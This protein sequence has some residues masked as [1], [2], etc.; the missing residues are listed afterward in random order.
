MVLFTHI[1]EL[2][3]RF[4]FIGFSFVLLFGS[5]FSFREE[6]FILFSRS[7]EVL[8]SPDQLMFTGFGEVLRI[9]LLI[10]LF[11]CF[12][13]SLCLLLINLYLFLIPGLYKSEM[14]VLLK[15][16]LLFCMFWVSIF[17]II[18][19][20]C[21]YLICEYLV[22]YGAGSSVSI[23]FEPRFGEF[24]LFILKLD[25]IFII[26]ITLLV[27]YLYYIWRS[28]VVLS[29]LVRNRKWVYLSLMV[30]VILFVPADIVLHGMVFSILVFIY[31]LLLFVVCIGSVYKLAWLRNKN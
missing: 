27:G 12:L 18:H 17:Y 13:V 20:Y 10:S 2:V 22:G 11:M 23:R 26:I 5:F 14:L 31:E 29:R 16:L 4:G 1:K 19:Y 30:L 9:Y 8:E 3:W 25:I 28:N 7:F 21:V 6:Y 24:V 15:Y